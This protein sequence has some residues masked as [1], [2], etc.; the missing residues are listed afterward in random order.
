VV[1]DARVLVS[2]EV[3]R[4]A[5][6]SR[7]T[8]SK[9]AAQRSIPTTQLLLAERRS[10]ISQNNLAREKPRKGLFLVLLNVYDT[11]SILVYQ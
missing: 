1:K 4:L 8:V 6:E 11:W 3:Q 2:D 7:H 10:A 9:P 5:T